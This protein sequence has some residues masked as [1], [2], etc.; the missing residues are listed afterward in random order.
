MYVQILSEHSISNLSL[1]LVYLEHRLHEVSSAS[2]EHESEG[3]DLNTHQLQRNA[4]VSVAFRVLVCH[5]GVDFLTTNR[6]SSAH[7]T[8]HFSLD[9]QLVCS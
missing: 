4:L 1:R 8:K 6:I 3:R 5:R 7:S 2:L 9:Y